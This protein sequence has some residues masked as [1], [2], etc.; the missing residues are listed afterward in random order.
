MQTLDKKDMWLFI[1]E[2]NIDNI[3]VRENL[4][5]F[6]GIPWTGKNI[7]DLMYIF[8]IYALRNRGLGVGIAENGATVN[9]SVISGT[10][11]RVTNTIKIPANP[12]IRLFYKL[13]KLSVDIEFY[14]EAVRLSLSADAYA[15]LGDFFRNIFMIKNMNL[16]NERM[17]KAL[18]NEA[19]NKLLVHSIF[20]DTYENRKLCFILDCN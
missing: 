4:L 17:Q 16:T 20:E 7:D 14:G 11:K 9:I 8:R 10:G 12:M 2:N 19:I 13:A 1:R 5:I 6:S 18:Y 3:S 15:A